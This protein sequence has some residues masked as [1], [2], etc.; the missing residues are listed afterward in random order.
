VDF[1]DYANLANHWMNQ[2]CAEPSWCSYADINKSGSVDWY[3]LA[4]FVEYWLE[5]NCQ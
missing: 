5:P 1:P 3:D 4:E 2:G